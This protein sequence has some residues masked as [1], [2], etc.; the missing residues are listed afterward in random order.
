MSMF[1]L[2]ESTRHSKT[3]IW[4]KVCMVQRN[5][6]AQGHGSSHEMRAPAHVGHIQS[7]VHVGDVKCDMFGI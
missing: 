5:T 3:V 4:A 6:W 1:S 7:T 2:P